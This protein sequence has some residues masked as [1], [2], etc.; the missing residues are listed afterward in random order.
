MTALDDMLRRCDAVYGGDQYRDTIAEAAA[1]FPDLA[2]A[3]RA[4]V[5][6]LDDSETLEAI[7]HNAQGWDELSRM[8][9]AAIEGRLEEIK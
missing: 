5:E 9:H 1:L 8:I 2:R 3:L 6:V 7:W 4:V